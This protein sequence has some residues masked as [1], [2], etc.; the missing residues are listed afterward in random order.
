MLGFFHDNIWNHRF[1]CKVESKLYYE[2]LD[3]L[4]NQLYRQQNVN[5]DGIF[6]I[7]THNTHVE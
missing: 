7:V 1:E 4:R 2:T 3:I 6:L 5:G